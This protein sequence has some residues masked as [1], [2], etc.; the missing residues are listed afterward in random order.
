VFGLNIASAIRLPE[1]EETHFNEIHIHIREDRVPDMMDDYAERGAFYFAAQGRFLFKMDS[2]GRF[3]VEDGKEITVEKNK[4]VSEQE[5]S[6]FLL[7][8]VMGAIILQRGLTPI[9]GCTVLKDEKS[10]ILGGKS[11]VGKST[12]AAEFLRNGYQL[13]ADDISVVS[14]KEGIPVVKKGIRHLKL[15]EDSLK[16]LELESGP[17]ERVRPSLNKYRKSF[18]GVKMPDSSELSAIIYLEVKNTEG[19]TMKE[20]HGIEKFN[21]VRDNLYRGIYIEPLGVSR[22]I[23]KTISMILDKVRVY[24]VTRPITP[25]KIGELGKFIQEKILLH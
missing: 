23:F 14:M 22:E 17:T 15:W 25:L 2:I 6:L 16:S 1:L 5:L 10:I 3:W 21:L 20:V 11:G 13:V 8:S 9:H 7:G 19:F 18:T 4:S 24:Q 12:L